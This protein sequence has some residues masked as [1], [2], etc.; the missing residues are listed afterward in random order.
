MIEWEVQMAAV[1][2]EMQVRAMVQQ[3]MLDKAPL[4]Y[5]ELA[6]SGNLEWVLKERADLFEETFSEIASPRIFESARSDLP[7]EK[8]LQ[9]D[10]ETFRSATEQALAVALDFPGDATSSQA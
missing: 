2:S 10:E 4:M 3:A 8:R 7:F 1:P 6:A 9:R 5:H